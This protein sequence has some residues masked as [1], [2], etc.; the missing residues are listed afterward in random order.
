MSTIPLCANSAM[1][2]TISSP[3][4]LDPSHHPLHTLTTLIWWRF[5]D[6]SRPET[7]IFRGEA[8][9]S[10]KM[11]RR[12]VQDEER[13]WEEVDSVAVSGGGSRQVLHFLGFQF[14]PERLSSDMLR[15]WRS[16]SS[17]ASG[18]DAWS[19]DGG[20]DTSMA[21]PAS[22]ARFVLR[23]VPGWN[24]I[25]CGLESIGFRKRVRWKWWGAPAD[26]KK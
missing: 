14:F 12:R 2:A 24:S 7:I 19:L 18:I 10:F 17:A 8:Q 21:V 4:C 20:A 5:F 11:W 6:L 15:I 16:R 9:S 23:C 13:F 3:L 25:L 26:C 22:C 1:I